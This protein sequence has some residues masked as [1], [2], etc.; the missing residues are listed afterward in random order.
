MTPV[1]I[2]RQGLLFLIAILFPCGVLVA[3]GLHMMDQERQRESKKLSD[4]RQRLFD[5]MRQELLSD[6][7]NIKLQQMTRLLSRN[8]ASGTGFDERVVLA[9]T[10]KDG[11]LLLPWE[12][13]PAAR[14]F[15]SQ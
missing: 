5:Q 10:I 15:R 1:R 11:Q 8:T 7:E 9:G 12:D 14:M 6:L 3:L 2:K 13:L 4:D